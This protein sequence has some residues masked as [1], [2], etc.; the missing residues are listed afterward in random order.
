MV[1]YSGMLI[2]QNQIFWN[3]P[4][5]KE[6]GVKNMKL[7]KFLKFCLQIILLGDK[8]LVRDNNHVT[9]CIVLIYNHT[10]RT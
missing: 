9:H 5:C 10:K 7:I 3:N 2:H 4:R 6:Y 1:K 8:Q